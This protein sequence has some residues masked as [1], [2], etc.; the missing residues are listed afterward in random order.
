MR[1][2]QMRNVV[3][4]VGLA[5]SS[6][7]PILAAEQT[8]VGTVDKATLEKVFPSKPGLFAL[9]GPQLSRRGRCSATRTCTRRSRWTPA[10]SAPA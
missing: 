3:L 8:D 10:R 6:A 9:R 1:L 2:P 7:L 5:G 4:A